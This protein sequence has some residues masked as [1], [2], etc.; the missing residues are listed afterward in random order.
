MVVPLPAVADDVKGYTSV[1][2]ATDNPSTL[3]PS[4]KDD[5]MDNDDAFDPELSDEDL[6]RFIRDS[7]SDVPFQSD[8]NSDARVNVVATY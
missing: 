7:S 1:K 6:A 8:K 4:L 2:N 3:G 5:S